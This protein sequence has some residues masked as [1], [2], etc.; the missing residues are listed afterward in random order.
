MAY[1]QFKTLATK[2]IQLQIKKML[3]IYLL[4]N[5]EYKLLTVM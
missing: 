4:R 2:A 3:L 1:H 5:T